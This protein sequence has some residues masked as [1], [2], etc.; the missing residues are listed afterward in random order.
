MSYKNILIIRLSAI[1]DVLHCTPLTRALR[2]EYPEAKISWIVSPKSQDIL[3]GNPFLDEIVVW[4]K[5]EWKKL[6]RNSLKAAYQSLRTL[7]RTLLAEQYDLAVD[8]HSQFL[9][10]FITWKSA[11]VRVGFS[12]A[13]EMAPLFYNRMTPRIGDLPMPQQYLGVLTAL[14][15]SGKNPA[16][17]MPVAPENCQNAGRI[18]ETYH[19]RPDDT[20]I[21]LNSSTTWQTKCWPPEHFARLGNLLRQQGAKILLTGAKSDIP[22]IDK[23]KDSIKGEVISLAGETSLKD[24]AAVAQKCDL[25]V[26][27]DTGPLHI[28]AAV[29]APTLSLYGPTD[30]RIYAPAG[31]QHAAVLTPAA[32][33]LCHKRRCDD[34]I[35]MARIE[36][37]TVYQEALKLLEKTKGRT[38][39]SQPLYKEV[40]VRKIPVWNH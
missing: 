17:I 3:Q 20:V 40:Q 39:N 6:A 38:K 34:F 10:G 27:G 37:E 35:C 8:V 11:P 36:P 9:P 18:W 5:D 15:I 30:P 7:Q 23:I 12:N 31:E 19:I 13:K 33:R 22:L 29:G 2:Q 26:S 1:G 14:G 28:A 32:C 24:L 21:V 16:M 25:F 4:D